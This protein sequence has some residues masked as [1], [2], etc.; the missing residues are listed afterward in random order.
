[1]FDLFVEVIT[2]TGGSGGLQAF[3]L[4]SMDPA[5]PNTNLGITT[6]AGRH[7]LPRSR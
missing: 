6:G 7:Y 4:Q 5:R 1:M 2:S 3:T